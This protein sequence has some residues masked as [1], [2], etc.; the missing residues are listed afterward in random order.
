MGCGQKKTWPFGF[1]VGC[2]DDCVEK[3]KTGYLKSENLAAV[4]VVTLLYRS[5]TNT[6]KGVDIL[7]HQPG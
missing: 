1:Y 6:F 5:R 4:V 7:V 3:C 2:A